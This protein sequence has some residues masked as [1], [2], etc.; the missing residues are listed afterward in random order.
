MTPTRTIVLKMMITLP[1][2]GFE[3]CSLNIHD[4]V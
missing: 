1:E 4:T 2:Q 3:W